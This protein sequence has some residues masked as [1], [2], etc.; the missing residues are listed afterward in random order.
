MNDSRRR[1]ILAEIAAAE[2]AR[3]TMEDWQLTVMDL[4]TVWSVNR[5]QAERRARQLVAEGKWRMRVD[6]Y[7]SRTGRR[8]ALYWRIE[9]ESNAEAAERRGDAESPEDV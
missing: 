4:A 9:D 5:N 3:W 8:A 7:D 1:A 6:G 2:Q